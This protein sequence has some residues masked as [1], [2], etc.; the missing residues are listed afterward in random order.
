MPI[1]PGRPTCREASARG[2]FARFSAR[3]KTKVRPAQLI[4]YA[5]PSILTL[6]IPPARRPSLSAKNFPRFFHCQAGAKRRL[7]W[8][9]SPARLAPCRISL[10]CRV[11]PIQRRIRPGIDVA[12]V[13]EACPMRL[14]PR[15]GEDP[16]HLRCRRWEQIGEDQDRIEKPPAG[17]FLFA[18]VPIGWPFGRHRWRSCYW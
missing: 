12:L 17:G 6:A 18:R 1:R 8:N 5:P 3:G 13:P 16:D 9:Q 10:P 4:H 14:G 7:P 15:C 11:K 2:F